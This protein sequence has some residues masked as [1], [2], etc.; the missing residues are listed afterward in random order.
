MRIAIIGSGNVG[1]ALAGTF[2]RS[3]HQVLLAARDLEKTRRVAQETGAQAAESAAAAAG[4]AEIVVLAVPYG[5]LSEVAREIRD[6][7]RD[8]VVIDL[9]NPGPQTGDG[10]SAAEQLADE[11]PEAHVAKALNTLFGAFM[12]QPDLREQ[13]VDA[14]F[15][16]DSDT[17]RGVLAEL[18]T[19]LG[20]RAI[21]AGGLETARQ[22][23]AMA[24]LNIQLQ[25]RYEGDW[26][27]T[28][29]LL[30]APEGA[31]VDLAGDRR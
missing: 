11:L 9:T 28:F 24:W 16:T 10:R 1:G 30:G 20:F 18:L 6:D 13:R 22:M 14:L 21:H 19:T 25:M 5:A 8:K 2:N 4:S 12:A 17:A 29:V 7:V 31:V 23:E 27:S 26:T 3:G 15:A